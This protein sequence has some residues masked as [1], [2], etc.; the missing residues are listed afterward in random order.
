M[1]ITTY[2]TIIGLNTNGL[3]VPIKR[4]MDKEEVVHIC[5]GIL[6]GHKKE[7]SLNTC[8]N[9]DGPREYWSK[10]NSLD[11]KTNAIL[12]HLHVESNNIINKLSSETEA[13]S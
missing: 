10:W 6:L 4:W 12:F 5:D 13:N 11:R 1:A 3:N 7:R 8:N 2:L 9:M